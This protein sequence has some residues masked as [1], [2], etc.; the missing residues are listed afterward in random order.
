MMDKPSSKTLL[1]A[2]MVGSSLSLLV[3]AAVAHTSHLSRTELTA[4]QLA[5]DGIVYEFVQLA[6][7]FPVEF[8][9]YFPAGATT[10]SY[11]EALR[12]GRDIYVAEACW[13]C[14]T[15][16]VRPIPAD[17]QR[18]GPRSQASE[19]RNELQH[20]I[21]RGT[22]RVGPD[23]SREGARRSNDWHLAH[24]YDATSVVPT[25]VMPAYRWFHDARGYPNKRGMA[26]ITYMQ[27]LGSWLDCY[28]NCLDR[29]PSTMQRDPSGTREGV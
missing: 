6:E 24:F 7:R 4:E 19:Y 20:P 22:R 15:Q 23:L 27:S 11:A 16:Q 3:V 28:P 18:W 9:R 13:H 17:E 14:H 29:P 1:F 8:N 2:G 12:L 26:I 10:E 21:M 25:S 5:A